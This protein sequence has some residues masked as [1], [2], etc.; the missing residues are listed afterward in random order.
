MRRVIRAKQ[1]LLDDTLR[2]EYIACIEAHNIPD[3]LTTDP[4]FEHKIAK[5][6]ELGKDGPRLW[7]PEPPSIGKII[8][9][10]EN[11]QATVYIGNDSRK[12]KVALLKESL[13]NTTALIGRRFQLMEAEISSLKIAYCEDGQQPVDVNDDQDFN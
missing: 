7:N 1:I 8:P 2:A 3:G 11:V 6:K 10:D 9:N 13:G 4:D 5:R 12:I